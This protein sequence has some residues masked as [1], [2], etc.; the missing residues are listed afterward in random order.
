MQNKDI[1]QLIYYNNYNY[2]QICSEAD[3][4]LSPKITINIINKINKY[5]ILKYFV[6]SIKNLIT[7]ELI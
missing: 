2:N 1:K 7:F 6:Y 4:F 5:C 3:P